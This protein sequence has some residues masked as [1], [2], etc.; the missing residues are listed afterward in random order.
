MDAPAPHL[1]PHSFQS[2]STHTRQKACELPVLTVDGTPWAKCKSKECEL[3]MWIRGV[4]IAALAVHNSRFLWM[5]RQPAFRQSQCDG[6]H[7]FFCL[8]LI[9]T[10]NHCVIG[11]TGKRTRWIGALHPDIERVV[12]EQVHQNR[13]DHAPYTKGN[14]EFERVVRGWRSSYPV[15]DLRLKG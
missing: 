9:S 5:H 11:V 7:Y 10:V 3:N 15:L 6:P 1:L 13:T 14:F 2:I 12:H 8:F 4:V